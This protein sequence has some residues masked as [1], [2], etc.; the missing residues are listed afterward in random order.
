MRQGAE[1]LADQCERAW[2]SDWYIMVRTSV[3]YHRVSDPTLFL[4]PVV[5]LPSQVGYRVLREEFRRQTLGGRLPR[6][7]LCAVLAKNQR[8]RM[9]WGRVRP[10]A[11]RAFKPT[12]LVH[13]MNC[14]TVL[15]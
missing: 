6:Q 14:G 11:T 8:V 15:A 5:G 13:H 9:R 2:P 7:S 1:L 4:E 10:G 12:G 3:V